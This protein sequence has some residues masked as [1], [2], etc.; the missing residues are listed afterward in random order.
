MAPCHFHLTSNAP[1]TLSRSKR[2]IKKITKQFTPQMALQLLATLDLDGA[3]QTNLRD[4]KLTVNRLDP[5]NPRRITFTPADK[6]VL[7]EKQTFET[8]VFLERMHRRRGY[9]HDYVLEDLWAISVDVTIVGIVVWALSGLWLWWE[10]K[11]TRKLGALALLGGLALFA[12]FL[13]VL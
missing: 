11:V 12:L 8:P 13:A 3:H 4:G 1:V 2:Q 10:M 9:Q 6:K 7:V 5:I